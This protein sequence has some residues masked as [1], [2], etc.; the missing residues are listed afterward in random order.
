MLFPYLIKYYKSGLFI[1]E[2][3]KNLMEQIQK[4]NDPFTDLLESNYDYCE[5]SF[6]SKVEF[7]N[8]M[9]SVGQ[10]KRINSCIRQNDRILYLR[11]K[12]IAGQKGQIKGIKLINQISNDDD[13]EN[14][15]DEVDDC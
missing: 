15:I 6:I 2:S 7:Q 4:D 1:P 13:D 3:E 11:D 9:K 5:S 10:W 14:T 8:T 12:C